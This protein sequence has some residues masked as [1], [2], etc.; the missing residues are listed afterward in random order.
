MPPD[1]LWAIPANP[2]EE[3][4]IRQASPNQSG[5]ISHR[6]DAF[7]LSITDDAPHNQEDVA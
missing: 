1:P 6:I 3:R 4:I 7:V 2:N 5:K